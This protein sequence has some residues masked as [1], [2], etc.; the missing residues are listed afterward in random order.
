MRKRIGVLSAFA[1][2]VALMP[3]TV[4]ADDSVCRTDYTPIYEIQGSGDESP[5][6]ESPSLHVTTEGIV[7]VDKQT[8]GELSGF[9]IQDPK[10]DG[11]S[12][13]SDGIFVNARDEW[14]PD[15]NVGDYVRVTGEVDENFGQTQIEW[16]D[17]IIT[18]RTG[19]RVN[20]T[21]LTA[22]EFNADPERYEGMLVQ[23]PDK[24][25]VTD[26]FNLERFGEVWLTD[27]G[28]AETPSNQFGP[29]ADADALAAANLANSILLDDGSTASNNVPVPH[30]H[31]QRHAAAR[32]LDSQLDRRDLLLIRPVP[33]HEPGRRRLQGREQADPRSSS[34][35]NAGGDLGERPQLLDDAG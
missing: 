29:G 14:G 10:G 1:M 24:L 2:V 5:L 23:Y 26:T 32:R 19:M 13:T 12:A 6:H 16:V 27:G 20:P 4:G 9:F 30:V 31:E 35:R 18:C 17:E 15:V 33:A 34:W 3:S 21:S 11:D 7:T 28:V 8:A 22:A 25:S